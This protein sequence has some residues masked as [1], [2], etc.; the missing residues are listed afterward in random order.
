MKMRV[1]LGVNLNLTCLEEAIE[2]IESQDA[3]S[4]EFSQN[5]S[6][7]QVLGKKHLGRQSDSGVQIEEYQMEIIKLK[8][9]SAELK[10]AAVEEKTKRQRME[11]K[12]EATEE[13][14]KIQTMGNL[15]RYIIQQQGGNLPPEIV[16]DL[17]SLESAPT[18]SH[19]R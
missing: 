13:K 15:L 5:D 9:E 18:L 10:S 14:T 16:A 4:K 12:A 11:A 3:S 19:A 17:D 7:A 2:H 1:L 6:L 8:A